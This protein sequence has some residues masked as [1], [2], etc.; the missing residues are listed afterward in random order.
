[1]TEIVIHGRGGQGAV[2]AALLLGKI[3]IEDGFQ[4]MISIPI[5]GAER[6]G[7]AI[8]A[9]L[10]ISHEEIKLYSS[11]TDPDIV[12]VFDKSLLATPAVQDMLKDCD[13]LINTNNHVDPADYP[14]CN[15]YVVDATGISIA[16][17]LFVSGDPVLNVPMIGAFAGM[18]KTLR[19]E[20][21][22]KVLRKQWGEQKLEL[23][24]KAAREAHEKVQKV[25]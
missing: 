9:N 14:G 4:D 17:D 15:V 25:N 11:I 13:V 7:A 12:L 24:M 20:S 23:N 6:R 22:E 1:M 10:R 3:A 2:T 5:I 8:R 18:T 16:L 21:I 19:V